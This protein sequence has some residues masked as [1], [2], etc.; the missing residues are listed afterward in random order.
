MS[1][2]VT[3]P[4]FGWGM[5]KGTFVEWRKRPGD[6]VKEGEVLFLLE[7]DKATEEVE[8]TGSGTL[9]I[10]SGSPSPGDEVPVG[11]VIAHLLAPGE[12]P[13]AARA[14]VA[15]QAPAPAAE[16]PKPPA[17]RPRRGGPA[18]SPR[19]RRVARELGVD[20][21]TLTGSG[22][23]GRVAERD[24]RE[25]A[26]R[27]PGPRATGVGAA[28][29][30]E[31]DAR[32]LVSL[33]SRVVASAGA[34]L[35]PAILHTALLARL[36]A[37]A[38]ASLAP[39]AGG[40]DVAVL[41]PAEGGVGRV[42]LR[43]ASVTGAVAMARVLAAKASDGG[44]ADLALLDA[45]SLGADDFAPDASSADAALLVFGRVRDGARMAVTLHFDQARLPLGA[46][47]GLLGR[48]REAV[49]SPDLWLA[50]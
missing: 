24:V 19:A 40:V 17:P 27:Q 46:A 39:A 25:A 34:A 11:T 16:A 29:T 35:D 44:A 14:P 9:H 43:S 1:V 15:V 20:W 4:R 7:S 48:V 18:A 49:E 12:S 3:I 37:A 13:P 32:R 47:S 41:R 21:S 2:E 45:G 28:L 22:T 30:V 50:R 5:E 31:A 42:L 38:A 10:P 6:P 23:S 36:S 33:A 8:A 26:A